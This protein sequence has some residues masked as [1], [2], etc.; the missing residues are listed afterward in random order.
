MKNFILYIFPVFILASI[1]VNWILPEPALNSSKEELKHYTDLQD[2]YS[3]SQIYLSLLKNDSLNVDYHFNYLI[4]HFQIEKNNTFWE[5][6]NSSY[7][8]EEII[9]KYKKLTLNDDEKTQN[10]GH[11]GLGICYYY[12]K[13]YDDCFYELQKISDRDFQYLNLLF[14]SFYHYFDYQQSLNYYDKELL[15]YPNNPISYESKAKLMVEHKKPGTLVEFLE[16]PKAKEYV[17]YT[18]KRFAFYHK[19]NIK[20][21]TKTVLSRVLNG[22]NVIGFIGALLILVIWFKYLLSINSNP[23][24]SILYIVITFILG[25]TFAFGTSLFTDFNKYDLN[26][27]VTGE[28]KNDLIYSIVGIGLIEETVKII[29]FLL[30]IFLNKNIKEPIDYLFYACISALGFAFL[31]N[32]IY[33]DASGIKTIQ[34]RALTATIIH[35]FTTS[36]IAYGIIIGKF[37]KKR[38]TIL[39]FM[40]FFIL[41]ILFHGIYDFW[42]LNATLKQFTLMPFLLLLM[43]MVIWTSIINNCLNNSKS[44]NENWTYNPE[45]LNNFL[46]YSLSFIFLFQYLLV[47][48]K[49]GSVVANYQLQKD[50]GAGLFLIIFL[51]INLSKFDYIPNYWAPLKFWDWDVFVNIPKIKPIYFNVKNLLDLPI[52]LNTYGKIGILQKQLPLNGKIISRE[53]ISWEK[54]WFLIELEQSFTFKNKIYNHL[55]IKSKTTNEMLL[56]SNNQIVQVRLVKNLDLLKEHKKLKKDF[57]LIDFVRI[58]KT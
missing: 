48:W 45:K 42:L 3:K 37:S 1:C 50:F 8:N 11:F 55:L 35:L 24:K 13:L 38:N 34:G 49:Y 7:S 28:W 31:E 47:A 32:L 46:L 44:T 5:G 19:K 40:L 58:K 25:M 21:Y 22:L 30:I 39:Y 56:E 53:L 43:S 33:F 26:F 4:S 29:P 16:D 27:N 41:A 17:N 6:I 9:E 20:D 2:N 14:G 54:D 51:T 36:L 57:I 23:K 15:N 52:E 10:I 18:E 12:L